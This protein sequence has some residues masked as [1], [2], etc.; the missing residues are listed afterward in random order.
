MSETFYFLIQG[1]FGPVT[2]PEFAGAFEG[3]DFGYGSIIPRNSGYIRITGGRYRPEFQR[4]CVTGRPISRLEIIVSEDQNSYSFGVLS[5]LVISSVKNYHDYDLNQFHVDFF[6]NL[7]INRR[8]T[9]K[10]YKI[11]HF[12]P[13]MN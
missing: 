12:L 7:R 8:Q 2:T 3:D 6:I 1:V 13:A 10:L 11:R 5:N 4:F 9:Q